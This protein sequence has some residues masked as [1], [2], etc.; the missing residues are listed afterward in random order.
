MER[1]FSYSRILATG[2]PAPLATITVWDSGTFNLSSIFSDDGITPKA[3]PFTTDAAGFFFFYAANA[4][5]DIQI[6][7]G[8]IP[9]PYTWGAVHLNGLISINGLTSNTLLLATAAAGTDFGIVAAGSTITFNLPTAS[10]ANRGVVST[11]TQTFAGAKTFTTPIALN[12]GGTGLNA[13]PANGQLLI[14]SGGTTFVLATLAGTANQVTVTNGAGT[15]TLSLPQSIAAAS[16]PTFTGLTLSGMTPNA[17]A[18]FGAVGVLT[19]VGPATNGQVL[20]GSTGAPPVWAALTAGANIT[21]TPGA[22][23]L[24]IAALSG[25]SSLNGL[26]GATQTFAVG[27]AG[28]DFAIVSSGTTHTFDIPDASA[29]NRG[30]VTAAAQAI[31]G[32]KTFSVPPAFNAGASSTAAT[33]SGR[34]TSNTTPVSNAGTAETDLMTYSLAANS[35]SANLKALR[36]TAWGSFAANA[37]SKQVRAYFGTTSLLLVNGTHNNLA[38]RVTFEIIRTGAATQIMSGEGKVSTVAPIV[39]NGSPT[40]TLSGA[41][42]IKITGQGGAGSDVTQLAMIVEPIG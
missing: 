15:I 36:V 39:L 42:T 18:V 24:Q 7:G 40:E 14:G 41:V 30:L 27:T 13:A 3:N 17:V 11:T 1:F 5:Y 38:W 37:N 16:S 12:S 10:A 28:S 6:S 8:G 35:L 25:I 9:T 33:V 4:L 19:S 23:T 34:L 20:L 2:A 26:T 21:L 32:L 22:G 31:A 29:T